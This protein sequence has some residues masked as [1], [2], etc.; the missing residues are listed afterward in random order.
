MVILFIIWIIQFPGVINAKT[1]VLFRNDDL[2]VKS[3]PVFEYEVLQVFR[4][5][6]IKP[7]FAVIPAVGDNKLTSDM[8]IADSLRSWYKKSWI[9]L[10]MHGYTHKFKFSELDKLEQE[11]RILA[12]KTVLKNALEIDIDWFAPPWNA[13]DRNTLKILRENKIN[14]LSGYLGETELEEMTY[15]NCNCNLFDGPLGALSDKI[16]L[17][18]ESNKDVLFVA[19]Y[20]TSYDFSNKSLDQ[21]DSLLNYI[22]S[23]DGVNILSFSKLAGDDSYSGMLSL[24]NKAGYRLKYLKYN[25][26]IR[27]IFLQVPMI[28]SYI[29]K[30]TKLAETYYWIGNYMGV[31][32]IY[33]GLMLR[34][35][36]IVS[37]ILIATIMLL[38]TLYKRDTGIDII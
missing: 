19:L 21:L 12:G 25:K 5:Y 35:W 23:L 11:R 32:R 6:N 8:P 4:H 13:I 3:D 31:N 2:S 29:K 34:F 28:S 15:I 14:N 16:E 26:Y 38:I 20:H 22:N 37:V 10:A 24:S 30:Q 7:L 18:I 27:K 17:A 9:D 33:T 1:I 36:I